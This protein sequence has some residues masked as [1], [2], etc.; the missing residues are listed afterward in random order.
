M[1]M[2]ISNFYLNTP[3]KHPEF[4]RMKISDIPDKIIT[5]YKLHDLLEPEGF[6]YITIVLGMYSLRH[7]GLIA[8]QLIK[9]CLNKHGY[10]QSKLVPGLRRHE[11]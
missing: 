11:W 4:I 2:D 6:I 1:T 9:Q 7:A 8:N 10:Q 3:L 5:E